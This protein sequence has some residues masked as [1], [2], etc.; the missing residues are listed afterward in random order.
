M[1]FHARHYFL[2]LV[3]LWFTSAAF[4]ATQVDSAPVVAVDHHLHLKSP[5][6]AGRLRALCA[7]APKANCPSDLFTTVSAQTAKAALAHAG[8]AR[9]VLISQAYLWGSQ[10]LAP[11]GIDGVATAAAVRE[12]NAYVQREVAAHCDQFVAFF[13]INPLSRTALDEIEYWART[14]GFAGIKIHLTNAQFDFR[15]A[16]HVR[17]LS[18]VFDAAARHGLAIIIHL[19]TRAP[20]YGA[21]D[22]EVFLKEV[23]PHAHG[24]VVQLAHA[25]GWSGID[26]P[27]LA[28]LDA[29]SGAFKDDPSLTRNLYFDLSRVSGAQ[30]KPQDAQRLSQ[31]IRTIGPG[32]FLMG[33]DWSL[34]S[35]DIAAMNREVFETI[36]L[37]PAE[38]QQIAS[39]SAPYL[40][41]GSTH[42][43]PIASIDPQS[44]DLDDLRPIAAEVGNARIVMLGEQTHGGGN[45]FLAKTRVLRYLHERLGFDVLAFESGMWEMERAQQL[46]T[47]GEKP[48]TVLPQAV[49]AIWMQSN[50][51]QPLLQYLDQDAR[52]RHPL[53]LTGFDMQ[54]SGSG[55]LTQQLPAAL[56]MLNT[57]LP[58]DHAGLDRIQILV[59]GLIANGYQAMPKFAGLETLDID[60]LHEDTQATIARIERSS[61]DRAA[62][63]RQYLQSVEQLLVFFK[64]IHAKQDGIFNLRD[65]QMAANL[66]WLL[67][68]GYAGK[69]V[70]VWAATA[71][72]I[73]SREAIDKE[74]APEMLPMGSYIHRKLAEQSYVMAFSAG[75]G[76]TSNFKTRRVTQHDVA[77]P[78]SI[79]WQIGESRLPYAYVGRSAMKELFGGKRVSWLLGFEPMTGTWPDVVDGIFFFS[80]EQPSTYTT[81]LEK[82]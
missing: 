7:A 18:A 68:M 44:A 11:D 63:W 10:Q 45:A 48:S 39:S 14:G 32:H 26:A 56:A 77:P 70:V 9:G 4:G 55:S 65:R 64:R 21:R 29:L 25:A 5:A 53:K 1:T 49:Y 2:A 41:G 52:S 20:D 61:V 74:G 33:S 60:R 76:A 12:E 3:S 54:L 59:A 47:A 30:T 22:M 42:I 15:S 50:Q 13:G 78:H 6:L 81:P 24:I 40:T 46:I 67:D 72:V 17:K 8:I 23:L 43:Q 51:V 73:N 34:P 58:G 36:P 82:N 16:E 80:T 75:K 27:T 62:F 79:E 28:A 57:Q 66:A 38:W 35:Q 71:H 31:I 69:K 37:K 19:R